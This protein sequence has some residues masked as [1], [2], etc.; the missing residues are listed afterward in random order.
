MA[1]GYFQFDLAVTP[2][3][4][5]V[6]RAVETYNQPQIKDYDVLVD[7]VLVHS[8]SYQRTAGGEGTVVYQI[9]VDR[10]DLTADGT[11]RV[12]FQEDADGRNYDPSIADV[13]SLPATAG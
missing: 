12:R 5:F 6:L 1:G 7:G 11:V 10:A 4:P 13:W 2:G 8:R 3:Q 9:L